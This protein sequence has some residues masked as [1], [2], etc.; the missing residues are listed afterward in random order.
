M[1]LLTGTEPNIFDGKNASGV[2]LLHLAFGIALF[3]Y[4]LE[5]YLHLR[6]HKGGEASEE[7]H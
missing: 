6:H 5:Y 1:D 7:H 3:G 2:P 4:S